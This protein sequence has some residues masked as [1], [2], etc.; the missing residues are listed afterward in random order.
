MPRELNDL[1][2]LPADLE[3]LTRFYSELYVA[4]FPDADE[5]E[6][7]ANMQRYL[8]LKRDGWYGRNN[9][10][11][12]LLMDEGHVVAASISDYFA[13][14]NFG[15][16]EFILVDEGRRGGGLGRRIHEATLALLHDDARRTG[17]DGLDANIIELNDPFRVPAER[18][19][20]DPFARA[21]AWNGWGYGRLR[22]R[23][24]QPSLSANQKPVDCLILAAKTFAPEFAK[25]VPSERVRQF[26]EAY[27]IWAMRIPVPRRNS[28]FRSM[29]RALSTVERVAIEPLASYVGRSP[30]PAL[31]VRETIGPSD[32]NFAGATAVYARAFPPGPSTVDPSTFARSLSRMRTRKHHHYHFWALA[33]TSAAP[34]H[35][36]AA[37][38]VMPSF[39]FGG[40]IALEAP[41]A[42]GGL[43]RVLLKRMEERMIRDEPDVRDWYI[44]CDPNS[45]QQRIF[46]HLGFVPVPAR[47]H[48]PQLGSSGDG[49]GLGPELILMRKGL[50]E[51]FE[52]RSISR[53]RL[54]TVLRGILKVVYGIR[55][56]EQSPSFGTAIDTFAQHSK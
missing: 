29:A 38:F 55:D 52:R 17:K 45:V 53:R 1:T 11:I 5:R 10:H 4:N 6:S 15:V 12:A 42:G 19:N 47:Y 18:D 24:V 2:D 51:E 39:G 27:L 3:L 8:T 48:Q 33:E 44:E 28:T 54:S 32:A 20:F 41:L 13:D 36:M 50:G 46:E 21:M 35:G 26:L 43:S 37:F 9:Y 7:L 23:Y 31:D 16:I 25:S 30:S 40:Y 56:P 34:I 22:F 14:V 49:T